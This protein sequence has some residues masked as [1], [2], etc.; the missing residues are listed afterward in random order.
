MTAESNWVIQ[1]RKKNPETFSELDTFLRAIDRFFNIENLSISQEDLTNRNFYHELVA[2]KE[3][4]LRIVSLLETIIPE[5][6]RNAYW[7]QKFAQTKLL[8]DRK[9]DALRD[10][11]YK[12]DS[13]EKS[14]LLLYDS[15]INLKGLVSDLIKTEHIPLMTFNNIGH[16][17]GKDIGENIF[18]NP[19]RRD[20]NPDIDVIDNREV[21]KV[22]KSITDKET[23]KYISLMLLHLFKLLRYLRSADNSQRFGSIGAASVVLILVRSEIGVF[24]NYLERVTGFIKD[25]GLLMLFRAIS[26]Q[27]AM[28]SKRVYEQELR[29]IFRNRSA[30]NIKARIE[31]SHGILKNLS[32]QSIIQTVQFFIPSIKGEDIFE[33]FITKLEQSLRLRDDVII[34]HKFLELLEGS[35]SRKER[36]RVLDAMIN[37][38]LYFQSFTFRLL[39]YED[40]EGFAAFFDKVLSIGRDLKKKNMQDFFEEVHRFKIFVETCIR[41]IS[42]RAELSNSQPDMEKIENSIRQYLH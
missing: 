30:S 9:R 28:E 39:R 2:V 33:S 8:S 36:Q 31:N 4:I 42:N 19:F 5:S 6:K 17:I 22:V 12:Q 11:L 10:E 16:L 29:E 24:R 34:L 35:K 37:Y 20:I 15:F 1:S 41:Q 27:F 14:L 7:F 40:Y 26:Y 13:P 32:E 23:K 21:S 3:V 25:E 18:F 38:M